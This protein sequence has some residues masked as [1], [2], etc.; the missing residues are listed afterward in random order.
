MREQKVLWALGQLDYKTKERAKKKTWSRSQR[1]N[2]KLGLKCIQ[3]LVSGRLRIEADIFLSL[4]AFSEH[5]V[6]VG[7]ISI[8]P[9]M[10]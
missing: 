2:R 9:A 5:S 3:V 1:Q 8:L 10:K 6:C 4:L 7:F